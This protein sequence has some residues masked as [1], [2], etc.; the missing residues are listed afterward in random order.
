M[1]GLVQLRSRAD[2][3]WPRMHLKKKTTSFKKN[4][5]RSEKEGYRDYLFD[6]ALNGSK[7]WTLRKYERQN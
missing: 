1:M 2:L 4:E 3:Q 6:F 5:Q 7:N